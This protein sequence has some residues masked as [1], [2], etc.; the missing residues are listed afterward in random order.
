MSYPAR[1]K[2]REDGSRVAATATRDTLQAVA[3]RLFPDLDVPAIL[4]ELGRTTHPRN[5]P[6][7]VIPASPTRMRRWIEMELLRRA[8]RENPR[9]PYD[10]R[11][12]FDEAVHKLRCAKHA[13]YTR[14][15]RKRQRVETLLAHERAAP[16]GS[17][18]RAYRG[19]QR[20]KQEAAELRADLDGWFASV[21]A[22]AHRD[23]HG[24]TD[25]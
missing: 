5:H 2:R 21:C 4:A 11:A 18:D 15:V 14:D 9:D 10:A 22:T 19:E 7:R 23:E 25:E 13:A 1:P 12:K 8:L 24:D 16:E 20:L 3:L 17:M 6:S